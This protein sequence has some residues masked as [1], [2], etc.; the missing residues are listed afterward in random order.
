[1]KLPPLI[2]IT[3]LAGSGKST[4]AHVL[5]EEYGYW[6]VKLAA[7]L[8]D[9]LRTLGLTPAQIEGNQKEVPS[10]LLLGH[11]PRYAMQTL[12][13]EW[14]RKMFGKDFWV[15]QAMRRIHDHLS[16]GDRVVVDDVR[17]LNEV[18]HL[19][20]AGGEI[21]RITRPGVREKLGSDP[22]PSEAEIYSITPDVEFVNRGSVQDLEQSI[23]QRLN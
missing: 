23:R 2:G 1:M 4:A 16:R 18:D 7:P 15:T 17:Y 10:D 21:W 5:I 22:H 13:E 14:G 20:A 3:A 6:L 19:R 11:T 12:G 8:K 9:M